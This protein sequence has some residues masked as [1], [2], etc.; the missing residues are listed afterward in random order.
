[1]STT[2][3]DDLQRATTAINNIQSAIESK[4]SESLNNVPVER[5]DDSIRSIP[6]LKI[7]AD[8]PLNLNFTIAIKVDDDTMLD[9][10]NSWSDLSNLCNGIVIN[11]NY[12]TGNKIIELRISMSDRR[13]NRGVFDA[14]VLNLN[15][16][17]YNL[18][19]NGVDIMLYNLYSGDPESVNTFFSNVIMESIF[20]NAGSNLPLDDCDSKINIKSKTTTN[21][22]I[23]SNVVSMFRNARGICGG[24]DA[25]EDNL[26][27]RF[28]HIRGSVDGYASVGNMMNGFIAPETSVYCPDM[29]A[30]DASV[31][32]VGSSEYAN[33][34]V[35]ALNGVNLGY[36]NSLQE[37]YDDVMPR[38]G[39]AFYNSTINR[40][41][42]LVI[43]A[44]PGQLRYASNPV[45]VS[46]ISSYLDLADV[47]DAVDFTELASAYSALLQLGTDYQEDSTFEPHQVV[48]YKYEDQQ[49]SGAE[50][51]IIEL[52]V[53]I[54]DIPRAEA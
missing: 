39:H 13:S 51:A 8:L 25:S 52:G 15:K 20:E 16:A 44:V 49:L 23:T 43:V 7:D 50:R 12:I 37:M 32:V 33:M 35:L 53:D 38:N 47:W 31:D 26:D 9:L 6:S 19:S 10:L 30:L 46:Q 18:Q 40:E 34:N 28:I 54:E 48:V 21:K 1:M 45:P 24:V 5:Y 11:S 41:L 36:K 4:T 22:I 14:S 17:F 27:L 42:G 3:V 2:I 29:S